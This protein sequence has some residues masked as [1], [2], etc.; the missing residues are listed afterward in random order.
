[1][2]VLHVIP[3]VGP[4]R[5]GPS[6]AM[7]RIA[8]ALATEGLSVEV[9]TTN[10]NGP[11]RLEVPLGRPV[12]EGGVVWR[13]FPLDAYFYNTSFA[14]ARWL[15]SSVADYD[16]VHIHAVFSF[17]STAAAF[18]CR[19]RRVPY[20]V[21][22]LGVLNRWGMQNRRPWL[23]RLSFRWIDCRI[24]DGAALVQYTSEQERDEAGLLGVAGPSVIIPNPVDASPGG[25]VRG[26][27][28]ARHP[29]L[30]DSKILLF[31]SRIDPKKGLDLLLPAFV[32]VR[33]LHPE[34]ILLIGGSGPADYLIEMQ[35]TA[36]ELGIA[37]GVRW[38]GFVAGEDKEQLLADA[39]VFVLPSYSENF[40]I[41]VVEAMAAGLPVV[42]TDQV[43]VA[44]DVSA[45]IVTTC[46]VNPIAEALGRL[47]SSDEERSRMR[48]NARQLVRRSYSGSAV[49][50]R[51]LEVY[52]SLSKGS[53]TIAPES[54]SV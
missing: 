51:L 9:A 26:A 42:V 48:A 46:E 31:L 5:G 44:R 34:A 49:A 37:T 45:G 8:A 6:F 41:S 35:R 43:G 21:R 53:R 30:A 47:L 7:R 32:E 10:D 16:V 14:L 18:A 25:A 54:I 1:M 17:C 13:Y 3:S 2:K 27:F 20:V 11:E 24:L 33:R 50:R 36:A 23:K 15:K 12:E 38:F 4:L 52:G 19:R 28:R 40:G 22:P 39:D 29:E